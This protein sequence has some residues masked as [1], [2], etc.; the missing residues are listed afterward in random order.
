MS[1]Y[2][3]K[4]TKGL[5]SEILNPGKAFIWPHHYSSLN[6]PYKAHQCFSVCMVAVVCPIEHSLV[7]E[8]LLE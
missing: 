5:I 8:C 7:P 4:G 1:I 2:V 6:Q 3:E